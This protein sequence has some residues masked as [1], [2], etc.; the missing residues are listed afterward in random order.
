MNSKRRTDNNSGF[1]GVA[2]SKAAGKWQA[3]ITANRKRRHLGLFDTPEDGYAAYCES[4][5]KLHGEF[6]NFGV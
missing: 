1:K 6:A 2:W 3:Y 4:A 5:R